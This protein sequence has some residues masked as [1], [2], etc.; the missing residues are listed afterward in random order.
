MISWY[1]MRTKSGKE[2]SVQTQLSF[3][4]PEVLLP[5]LSAAVRRHGKSAKVLMPLFP[6]YVFARFD[7]TSEYSRVKY[8]SGVREF[9]CA[10]DLPVAV[11]GET[12]RALKQRCADGP[13]EIPP[14]PLRSGDPVRVMEGPL[15]GLEAVFERYLSGFERVAILL[16][17]MEKLKPRAVLRADV[18]EPMADR[19][20]ISDAA[21]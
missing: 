13:V 15:R 3:I 9:V 21:Q 2:R 18:L 12:I 10:G 11:P 1:L 6:C 4:L 8:T 19:L 16:S 20:E 17:S 14:V 5:L 7:L